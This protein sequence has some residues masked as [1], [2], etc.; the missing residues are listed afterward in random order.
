MCLP[1]VFRAHEQALCGCSWL[2]ELCSVDFLASG[3]QSIPNGSPA[4]GEGPHSEE[5][6]YAMEDDDSD[7]DLSAWELS[8]GVSACPPKEQ[9]ADLFNEDWDLEL[10]ADQGNPYGRCGAA[11]VPCWLTYQAAPKADGLEE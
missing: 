3:A 10:K 8:E 4:C 9:A 6:D 11:R 7:G 5:E 2:E 1:N